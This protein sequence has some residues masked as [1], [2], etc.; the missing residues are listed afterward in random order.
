MGVFDE[1]H[2]SLKGS[3]VNPDGALT[4]PGFR[5]QDYEELYDYLMEEVILPRMD[6]RDYFRWLHTKALAFYHYR[7]KR[8]FY[9]PDEPDPLSTTNP[10][11][12]STRQQLSIIKFY[13]YRKRYSKYK[14]NSDTI[15]T[16]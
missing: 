5:S 9:E 14:R 3:K 2:D 7:L 4:I 15:R 13:V 1:I 11:D 12:L 8:R 10:E 16:R 6:G